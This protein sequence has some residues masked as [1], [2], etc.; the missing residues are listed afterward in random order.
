M[1]VMGDTLQL[2]NPLPF[3]IITNNSQ[4]C[5]VIICISP[6]LR[7]WWVPSKM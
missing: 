6:S 1:N 5:R 4:N 2:V 7:D 3:E